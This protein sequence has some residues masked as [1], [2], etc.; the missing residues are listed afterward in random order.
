[1]QAVMR[2]VKHDACDGADG[3]IGPSDNRIK[4]ARPP[5]VDVDWGAQE[6]QVKIFGAG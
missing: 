3:M 1:M 4:V 5:N 2:Y 6:S